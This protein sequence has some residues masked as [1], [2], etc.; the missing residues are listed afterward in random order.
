MPACVG[1]A[2]VGELGQAEDQAV[3]DGQTPARAALGL[4]L[5][6]LVGADENAVG[7]DALSMIRPTTV[8]SS[9]ATP[10]SP[11]QN[12]NPLV[13]RAALHRGHLGHRL[14]HDQVDLATGL[15]PTATETRPL[16]RSVSPVRM[17][18]GF[19]PASAAM[20]PPGAG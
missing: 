16:S 7:A 2:V 15:Y 6:L 5:K 18:P 4:F 13:S 1:V 19:V 10:A 20:F 11:P 3:S 17:P 14:V 12:M 9:T 8:A